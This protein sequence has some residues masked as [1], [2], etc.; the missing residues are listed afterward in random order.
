MCGVA[1]TVRL[2]GA[3]PDADAVRRMNAALAHRGPDGEGL[4]TLGPAVLGHRRL[5]VLDLTAAGAQPM[6]DASGRYHVTYNGEIYNHVELREELA[7]LGVCFRS[8]CDTE[9]LVEGYARWG[10]DVLQRLNGM[11]SFAI[12]D[13]Q[14][15]RLF[16][17]RD[18]FGE[19]PFFY[20]H[21][22]GRVLWFASEIKALRAARAFVSRADP[23]ALVGF[24][25]YGRTG[26]G[27]GTFFDGVRQLPPAHRLVLEDGRLDVAPYWSLPD[28]P[29]ARDAEV[30]TDV[31]QVAH[32]VG[33]SVRLR[34]RSD[35][36]VG[37]CLS[38]G[39]D[40]SAVV[41]HIARELGV[42]A[43]ET[44]RQSTFSAAF[45]D[46]PSDEVEHARTVA[47]AAAAERHEIAPTAAGL[48][49]ELTSLV[50][51]HDEPFSGP[52]I[53]AEWKVMELAAQHNV[54]VLL[55]G[56]GADEVFAGYHF[57]YSD[58]WYGHL[59]A[60]RLGALRR[61]L[62]AHT[63]VHGRDAA[64]RLMREAL[65]SRVPRWVRRARGG[66]RVPWL[67]SSVLH[68]G[69]APQPS[70]P[71]D[72]RASLRESQR[73]RMLP[74]LLR[75]TDR[76]SMAFSREVRLPFLDH[77]LVELVDALPDDRKLN[78]GI[79]KWVLREALR[80]LV[81]DPVLDRTDKVGFAVPTDAWMRG[82]L[83][84]PLRD[85][86]SSQ[87]CR[88][89]GIFARAGLDRAV[90]AFLAGDDSLRQPVWNAFLAETWLSVCVE[91]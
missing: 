45:P 3:P 29:E 12:W 69:D 55:N 19:K 90:T 25:A 40:S 28:R 37:S 85:T 35:V 89:R 86:L 77:R 44:A 63:A 51:A 68:A 6:A 65:R 20:V 67:E 74:H 33:D 72:L 36:E 14:E 22:A 42:T 84:E 41:L 23:E 75:Q 31:E 56:Q 48:A 5:A 4:S 27:A 2:D 88:E 79:T 52:S 82:A 8:R 81:P 18:R 32:L 39:L 91:G 9:V 87:R 21:D 1:G 57:Y 83:A 7:S 50:A 11:F 43:G 61:G 10:P 16:A 66:P 78:G 53:Y 71:T 73:V 62:R 47:A 64:R 13:T 24:L 34:L 49:T 70:R 58:L 26:T 60:G 15:R 54:T 76:S 59:R 17:A 38:G 30:S 80:G 46:A